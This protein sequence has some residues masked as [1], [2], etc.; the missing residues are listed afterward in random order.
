[1]MMVEC[2]GYDCDDDHHHDND[3][4]D[5][6]DQDDED[7]DEGMVVQAQAATVG[8]AVTHD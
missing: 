4:A 2:W 6:D 8:Q 1:M 3:N 7:D 5:D